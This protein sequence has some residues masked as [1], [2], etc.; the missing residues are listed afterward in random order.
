MK[1]NPPKK[2]AGKKLIENEA[3]FPSLP[4]KGDEKK[5]TSNH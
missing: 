4:V 3:D 5:E 2:N 1:E